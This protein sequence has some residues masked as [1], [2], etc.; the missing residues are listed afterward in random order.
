MKNIHHGFILVVLSCVLTGCN[1]AYA[2]W[3]DGR[4]DETKQKLIAVESQLKT[5]Q[6]RAQDATSIAFL[7][8][9]GCVVFFVTGT[10][11]G[12]KTRRHA[13]ARS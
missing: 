2:G 11:L 4:P 9:I 5:Q 3:F 13:P 7:L 12:A 6:E 1:P 10:A 8:A